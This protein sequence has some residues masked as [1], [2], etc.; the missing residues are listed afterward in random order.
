MEMQGTLQLK[1][2]I[3]QNIRALRDEE[4]LT[5][6][7]FGAR[8]GL[9]QMLVY[10]WERGLHRPSDT[11]LAALSLAFGVEPVWFYTDHERAAA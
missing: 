11:H 1:Q 8:A 6:K 4:G 5:R 2:I 7:A 3:G 10:K 9:D